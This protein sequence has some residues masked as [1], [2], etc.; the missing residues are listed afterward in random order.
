[1]LLIPLKS[2]RR[3]EF[4][5]IFPSL[6]DL[7]LLCLHFVTPLTF[8]FCKKGIKTSKLV[9]HQTVCINSINEDVRMFVKFGKIH[10]ILPAALRTLSVSARLRSCSRSGMR[11]GNVKVIY[12]HVGLLIKVSHCHVGLYHPLTTMMEKRSLLFSSSACLSSP[13][14]S[15]ASSVSSLAWLYSCT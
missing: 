8:F 7:T 14:L 11:A 10:L 1:M 6:F 3:A 15:K 9:R 2:L 4:Y 5:T 12:C 13:S